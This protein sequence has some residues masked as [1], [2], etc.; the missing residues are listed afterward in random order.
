P[1]DDRS[2]APVGCLPTVMHL[3]PARD[4]KSTEVGLALGSLLASTELVRESAQT[5]NTNSPS[6]EHRSTEA[7]SRPGR[8]G[9]A[10]R[11]H[12]VLPFPAETDGDE[13][14]AGPLDGGGD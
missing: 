5:A 11:I 13:D 3:A 4:R 10:F 9:F 12:D 1:E 14:G 2:R 7:S 8:I 6:Q